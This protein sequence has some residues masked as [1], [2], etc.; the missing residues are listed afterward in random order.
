MFTE[1]LSDCVAEQENKC[2]ESVKQRQ[3]FEQLCSE[4]SAWQTRAEQAMEYEQ[5]DISPEV[6]QSLKVSEGTLSSTTTSVNNNKHRY[7]H[8]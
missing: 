6:S 8:H 5:G 2:D 4:L 3:E 1:Q 7:H